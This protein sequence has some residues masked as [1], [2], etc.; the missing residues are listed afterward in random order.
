M[1]AKRE[2]LRGRQPRAG[3]TVGSG[4]CRPFLAG[5]R[6]GLNLKLTP[7]RGW[8]PA[9]SV[10]SCSFRAV[11]STFAGACNGAPRLNG[12]LFHQPPQQGPQSGRLLQRLAQRVDL[13][14][15]EHQRGALI[16]AAVV[17]VAE[18]DA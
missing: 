8:L 7:L 17:V 2:P 16:H 11:I 4:S 6:P 1:S 18:A 13:R 15:G 14:L 9:L 3:T 12:T 10:R 5:W